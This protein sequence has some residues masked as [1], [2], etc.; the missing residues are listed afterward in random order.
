MLI[1]NKKR[2]PRGRA[3]PKSLPPRPSPSRTRDL[4][5]RQRNQETINA[6]ANNRRQRSYAHET[7]LRRARLFFLFQPDIRPYPTSVNT[8]PAGNVA[9]VRSILS[10]AGTDAAAGRRAA[11]V[12]P[13]TTV[14]GG[15]HRFSVAVSIPYVQ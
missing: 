5:V 6:P 14:W 12:R 13:R 3:F 9:G 7:L 10:T 15:G 8:S 11:K 1:I 2:R 4:V